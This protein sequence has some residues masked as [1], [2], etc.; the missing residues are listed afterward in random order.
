MWAGSGNFAK[1]L[2]GE[3]SKEIMADFRTPQ[4]LLGKKPISSTEGLLDLLESLLGLSQHGAWH[5]KLTEYRGLQQDKQEPSEE[6][7]A[8]EKNWQVR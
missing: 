7:A 3:H 1:A 2:P 4:Q 8:L 6:R 5:S